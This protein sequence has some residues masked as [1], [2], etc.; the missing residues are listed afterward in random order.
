MAVTLLNIFRLLVYF[1]GF[2]AS[3]TLAYFLFPIK[4]ILARCLAM[5]MLAIALNIA[6]MALIT[7]EILIRGT[8]HFAWKELLLLL[9]ALLYAVLVSKALYIFRRINGR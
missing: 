8:E 7:G 3:V 5:V 1:A 4:H 2:A 6:I 9:G